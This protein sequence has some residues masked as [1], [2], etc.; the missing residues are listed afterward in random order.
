[1]FSDINIFDILIQ[2]ICLLFSLCVHEASHA[3][4]AELCGDNTARFMGR[5]TL[6]PLAHI[7]PIGTVIMPLLMITTHIPLIGW[8]KPVPVNPRN[9]RNMS[10][11]NILVSL[12]G[13]ASNLLL[14][15]V[16]T[17]VLRV[18]IL[19]FDHVPGI[20]SVSVFEPMLH[21]MVLML[22]INLALTLFNLIPVPPLDGSHL[23][24]EIIGPK[25][26]QFM[27]QIGPYGIIVVFLFGGK[28]ISG[29]FLAL[30]NLIIGFALGGH[31]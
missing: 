29:P 7:D 14:V 12:A 21:V 24:Y 2:Y 1:M 10:R 31:G 5:I 4:T 25:G 22:S 15:I 30:L 13:P 20:F 26:Q 9:F 27:D 18:L 8:A 3:K 6:N 28:L 17:F 11:G 19:F 23:L 16:F